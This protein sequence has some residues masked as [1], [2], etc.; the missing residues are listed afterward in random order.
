MKL[1]PRYKSTWRT[2]KH[3]LNPKLTAAA[4]GNFLHIGRLPGTTQ[5]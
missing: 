4:G 1:G 5:T 2:C 3:Y